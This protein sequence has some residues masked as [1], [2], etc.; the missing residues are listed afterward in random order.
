MDEPLSGGN[1]DRTEAWLVNGTHLSPL[2][3]LDLQRLPLVEDLAIFLGKGLW[4]PE[5][6]FGDFTGKNCPPTQ[7]RPELE[8]G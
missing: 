2:E 3:C 5:R 1:P 4:N 7:G 8:Q 6:A